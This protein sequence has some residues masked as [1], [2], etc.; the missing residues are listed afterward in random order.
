[1]SNHPTSGRCKR[2]G[3][4]LPRVVEE[5]DMVL[6]GYHVDKQEEVQERREL[7]RENGRKVGGDALDRGARC[8]RL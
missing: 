4:E 6:W 7:A 2:C 5:R 3:A 8:H 1:M